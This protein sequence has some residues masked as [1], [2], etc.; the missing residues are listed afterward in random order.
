M[1]GAESLLRS[2][3]AGGVEVCFTNPGTS[4][5]HFVA[6][7][8]RVPGMRAVLG[9]QENVVTGA[10]D[11]YGRMA[12]KPASTL[13]HL[14]PGLANGLA[15]LHN[16]RRAHT[17][18]VN[19]VGDHAVDHTHLDAPLTSDVE[20]VAAPFS[21]WVRTSKSSRAVGRD[22]AQAVAAAR[23]HPGRIASLI[24][25]ADASWNE[26]GVPAQALPVPAPTSAP[27]ETIE[28]VATRLRESERPAL[29][30]SGKALR[31]RA[32]ELAAAIGRATGARVVSDTFYGRLERGGDRAVIERLPY[33]PEQAAEAI[34]DV[35]DLVLVHT[36]A[37]VG[38]FAYPDKPSVLTAPTTR[39]STL[40][41]LEEDAEGALEALAD[42]L[43]VGPIEPGAFRSTD[44]LPGMPE[45]DLNPFTL[46]QAVAAT[47]RENTIVV[48][49]GATGGF[50][51]LPITASAPAHDWL[52]LTG[53]AIGFG[54]PSAIGAAIACPG[55]PVLNLQADG[56][57]MY[58]VQ[59]LWTQARESLDVTTVILANRSYGIL[60]A[61]LER[62]GAAP[63]KEAEK[64]F[65]LTGPELDF[66]SLARGMGVPAER[67][68][69]AGAMGKALARAYATPGPNLIEAIL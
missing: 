33:F 59:S 17:P 29:L 20:A 62:T 1:N 46:A 32:L 47:M 19:V 57:A 49:E 52:S 15:N 45:G 30:M 10:A 26:P 9:L 36:K 28:E 25:P 53:G 61:E 40:A 23:T 7:L 54:M 3:V 63:S 2:L 34:A 68:T 65:D 37:P 41:E 27:D 42:R 6:A 64:L 50:F 51:A 69:D 56:S 21:H 66:V 11:G 14:G 18:I 5:M 38:F 31:G 55:R 67:V 24:L 43:G 8:D 13:L 22:A 58:T 4:E 35:T 39:V 44:P 48:D 60:N 16:A 12:D